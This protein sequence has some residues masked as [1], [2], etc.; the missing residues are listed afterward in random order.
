MDIKWRWKIIVLEIRLIIKWIGYE[1]I[2]WIIEF[3]NGDFEKENIKNKKDEYGWKKWMYKIYNL[4]YCFILSI[5]NKKKI[6]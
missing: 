1:I 4:E 6:G 3:K 5:E 2:W